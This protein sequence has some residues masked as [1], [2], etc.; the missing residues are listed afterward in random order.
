VVCVQNPY[1]VGARPE[2]HAFLRE[3]GG[4][5]VAFVPFFAIAGRGRERGT[6]GADAS[7]DA[8]VDEVASA[9]GAT[10]AQIRLAWT[11]AQGRHVLGIPGTADLEHLV[12]NAAAAAIRLSEDERA[13]L[14]AVPPTV[15]ERG[16]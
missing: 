12:Q 8:K 15:G 13:A 3:C 5:G 7:T 16:W 4:R 14:E 9:H 10:A 11:L 1:G 6:D 2:G